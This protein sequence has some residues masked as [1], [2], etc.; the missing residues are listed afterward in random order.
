MKNIV[1]KLTASFALMLLLAGLASAD[2]IYMKIEGVDGES[3]IV[4]VDPN[5]A[6]AFKLTAPGKYKASLL[7]PAVQKIR[8]SPSKSSATDDKHKETIEIAS[9]SFGASNPTSVG[10]TGMSSGR[11]ASTP[12]VSEIVVTKNMDKSSPMLAKGAS[13][14]KTTQEL[15]KQTTYNGDSYYVITLTD[16]MVSSWQTSSSGGD[17]PMES[18]SLNFTKIEWNYK[19]QDPENPAIMKGS[20]NLKENVK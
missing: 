7:L 13:K 11:E 4:E 6:C 18:I 17:R 20:W 12:S 10:S 15:K 5:G 3:Q 16:V 19:P 9:W 1:T 2:P 8:E 14:G